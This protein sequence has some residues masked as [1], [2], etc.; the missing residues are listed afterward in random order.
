MDIDKFK[1]GVFL[2]QYDYKSFSPSKVE[3]EW[4]IS[5]PEINLLLSEANRL[6]G[7]LNAFS[8]ISPNVDFFIAMYATKEANISSK[9]EGTQSTFEEVLLPR[10]LIEPNKRGDWQEVQNYI[11]A[12]NFA[13]ERLKKLPLSNRLLKETHKILM[14]GVIG[15]YKQPGE[16]R[17]SQNWIGGNSIKNAIF[18]PP[19]DSEVLELMSDL[20]KFLNNTEIQVPHLLK[21]AISHYQFETIHPFLD[22]NGRLGRLLITLYLV[23]FK[24]LEKPTLYLSSYFEKNKTDYYDRLMLVR[25]KSDLTQWVKFFLQG[26]IEISKQSKET[27]QKM[28]ELREEMQN[29]TLGLGKRIQSADKLLNVLYRNPI[30]TASDVCEKLEISPPTANSLLKEFTSLGILEEKTGFKRNRIFYFKD[31]LRLFI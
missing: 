30:V 13:I 29:K 3:L 28:I 31:Y 21:I 4:I 12:M 27:F 18:V 2:N 11:A 24:L 5:N 8:Q 10:E 25:L 23:S 1:S 14:S 6:L 17:K 20:E 19:H 16:F 7:E 22:G 9:I 15:E 26:V